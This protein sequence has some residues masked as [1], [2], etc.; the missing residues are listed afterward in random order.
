MGIAARSARAVG[1]FD[2][3]LGLA[4][5]SQARD[6]VGWGQRYAT[7]FKRSRLL[8]GCKILIELIKEFVPPGK[9][10]IALMRDI[11]KRRRRVHASG[12]QQ[13]CCLFI[14]QF[15]DAS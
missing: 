10:W 9:I 14:I 15:E 6:G 7:A 12:F 8:G 4:N 5:A 3:N 13:D 11:P 1:I 2:G